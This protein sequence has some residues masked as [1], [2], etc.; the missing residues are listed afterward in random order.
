MTQEFATDED[1]MAF[2][3]A[4]EIF[5]CYAVQE[6]EK[7]IY[8]LWRLCNQSLLERLA[9]YPD[10]RIRPNRRFSGLVMIRELLGDIETLS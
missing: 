5:S 6:D 1:K 9:D 2:E 4:D 8:H 3:K 10:A 7:V